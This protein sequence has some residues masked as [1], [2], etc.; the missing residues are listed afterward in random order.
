MIEASA[1]RPLFE[2][3]APVGYFGTSMFPYAVADDG[4]RF[5]ISAV[6]SETAT[7]PLSVVVNWLAAVKK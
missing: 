1:P 7:E 4:K 5:L 3:R 2:A 6:E